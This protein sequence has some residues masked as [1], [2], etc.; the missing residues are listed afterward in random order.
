MQSPNHLKL[1]RRN[2]FPPK[3]EPT[4]PGNV[5]L[6][7]YAPCRLSHDERWVNGWQHSATSLLNHTASVLEYLRLRL[8]QHGAERKRSYCHD[9]CSTERATCCRLH[10]CKLVMQSLLTTTASFLQLILA[11]VTE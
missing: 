2:R 10:G 8:A 6:Q 1:H 9:W 7:H 4:D 3:H 5:S 11:A